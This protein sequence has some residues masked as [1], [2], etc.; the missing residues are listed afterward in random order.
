MKSNQPIDETSTNK[1]T[2]RIID[3]Y[4][5]SFISDSNYTNEFF[6]GGNI[7]KPVIKLLSKY[8]FCGQSITLQNDDYVNLENN[9][10]VQ[11]NPENNNKYIE[12]VSLS[13]PYDIHCSGITFKNIISI[14]KTKN[15]KYETDYCLQLTSLPQNIKNITINFDLSSIQLGLKWKNI[16]TM[17]K[18]DIVGSPTIIADERSEFAFR[19]H[20]SHS[21]CANSGYLSR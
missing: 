17:H 3:A 21:K 1:K 11:I 6:C 7:P 5:N 13:K 4:L 20:T 10:F 2:K 16:V 19:Q 12:Y 8:C 15:N 14:E 9:K 18:D